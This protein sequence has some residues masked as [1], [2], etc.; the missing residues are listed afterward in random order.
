MNKKQWFASGFVFF[1]SWGLASVFAS[2]Y[3]MMAITGDIAANIQDAMYTFLTWICF[4]ASF[5]CFI[6]GWLEKEGGR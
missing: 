2:S 1:V 5:I 4:I 6:C 3:G